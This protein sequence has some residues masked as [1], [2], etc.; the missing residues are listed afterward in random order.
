VKF[1][2]YGSRCP[3]VDTPRKRAAAVRRQARE[4]AALPLFAD[5]IAAEQPGI[6]A[7]MSDRAARWARTEQA[8]R[9]F[10]AGQWRK[11]RAM[12]YAL[13]PARRDAVRAAMDRDGGPADPVGWAY[14]IRREAGR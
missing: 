5:Q 9:D 3:F 2:P 13:S 4:R 7:V 1:K 8:M 11:I 12:F 10:R 14:L 6:D